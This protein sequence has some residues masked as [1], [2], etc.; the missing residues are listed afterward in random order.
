MI[1]PKRRSAG[2]TAVV[3]K[4]SAGAAEHMPVARVANISGTINELKKRGIWVFGASG[5]G[6]TELWKADFRDST[7]IVIGSEGEGMGK[8]V[9]E[10]CD[11]RVF[12]PMKGKVT[13]LNASVAAAILMYEAVRQRNGT[14]NHQQ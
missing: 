8:L 13:S 14:I 3:E 6:E 2:I 1:I 9:S 4:T 5:S 7:A 11:Y 12:I 10:S